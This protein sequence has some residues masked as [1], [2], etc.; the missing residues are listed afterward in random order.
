MKFEKRSSRRSRSRT[1]TRRHLRPMTAV[2]KPRRPTPLSAGRGEI[3]EITTT[4]VIGYA[5]FGLE[6]EDVHAA[7]VT[8]R[9]LTQRPR[10][11]RR[12]ILDCSS[13]STP[14]S[15]LPRSCGPGN[16]DSLAVSRVRSDH[17]HDANIIDSIDSRLRRLNDEIKTLTDARAALDGRV[18]PTMKRR[19]RKASPTV[20]PWGGRGKRPAA[21]PVAEPV[22]RPSSDVSRPAAQKAP[23]PPK[24]TPRQKRGM[25]VF[26][27]AQIERLLSENGGLST[28]ALRSEPMGT[29]SDTH[30]PGR[31]RA[32]RSDSQ[33]GTASRHTMAAIGVVTSQRV[34]RAA[35]PCWTS[36]I[37][38][39]RT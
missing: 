2:K 13:T 35:A 9:S 8:P 25:Q 36:A 3:T 27:A 31:A 5:G 22:S 21:E 29:R 16:G 24:R 28:S 18:C 6:P 10:R 33:N 17:D 4:P 20:A 15:D 34:E 7:N 32:S 23:G 38:A 26:S 14:C 1:W 30:S 37:S 11:P 12:A 39:R 19:Q